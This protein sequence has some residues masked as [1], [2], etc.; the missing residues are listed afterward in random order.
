MRAKNP[1]FND[2]TVGKN[3]SQKKHHRAFTTTM[4]QSL[5]CYF[6]TNSKYEKG[7]NHVST[8]RLQ[9]I[10]DILDVP[11]S[12]FY[13]DILTKG[14]TSAP[15]DDKISSKIAHEENSSLFS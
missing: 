13:A 6:S 12:F 15:Y 14:K 10:A 2:I 1:H 5:R 3:S 4:R 9:K 8:G 11:V 7:I